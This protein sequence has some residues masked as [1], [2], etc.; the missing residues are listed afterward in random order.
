MVVKL[1]L[2]F[3]N[4]DILDNIFKCAHLLSDYAVHC[5]CKK[6]VS[7]YDVSCKQNC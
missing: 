5:E 7:K 1:I 6:L 2:V 3:I 4:F